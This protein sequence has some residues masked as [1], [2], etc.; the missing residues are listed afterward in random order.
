MTTD[1]S[2]VSRD[3]VTSYRQFLNLTSQERPYTDEV[4]ISFGTLMELRVKLDDYREAANNL[5]AKAKYQSHQLTRIKDDVRSKLSSEQFLVLEKDI[6]LVPG[7]SINS[8][9]M[10]PLITLFLPLI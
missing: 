7:E 1:E 3:L 10:L 2:E 9:Y 5:K 8:P 6:N 4:S